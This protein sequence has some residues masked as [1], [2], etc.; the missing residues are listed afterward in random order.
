MPLERELNSQVVAMNSPCRFISF[1]R[2]RL[3]TVSQCKTF[4]FSTHFGRIHRDDPTGLA[5]TVS[6]EMR[7]SVPG[8][9]RRKL[10]KS[11]K[12]TGFE[13]CKFLT[14][15]SQFWAFSVYTVIVV[16]VSSFTLFCSEGFAVPS[17]TWHAPNEPVDCAYQSFIFA[18]IFP[19][20][21]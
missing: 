20:P 6:D 3:N 14:L 4:V 12:V 2:S 13:F 10:H 15:F 8:G 1:F 9:F 5:L 7:A 16:A 11:N 21:I 17:H 19:S 18:L